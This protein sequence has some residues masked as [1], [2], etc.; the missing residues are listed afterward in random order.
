MDDRRVI[1]DSKS[2]IPLSRFGI[3]AGDELLVTDH[4]DGVWT[5]ER[6]VTLTEADL[7]LREILTPEVRE[8]IAEAEAALDRGDGIPWEVVKAELADA[9]RRRSAA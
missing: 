1:A 9:R 7:E 8:R 6:A 3:E 5:V 4:G 2:R